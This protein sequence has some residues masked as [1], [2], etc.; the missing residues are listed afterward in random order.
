[1]NVVHEWFNMALLG[2]DYGER[3][4]GLAL[5]E[6]TLAVPLRVVRYAN[7]RELREE[8]QRACAEHDVRTIVAGV[9]QPL[10]G[11]ASAQTEA[12]EEFIGWLRREFVIPVVTEDERLTSAF[13]KRLM[14]DWKG[15]ADDDAI[16]ASL[17]LQSYIERTVRPV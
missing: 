7:R 2:I 4:I 16:A 12:S 15:K 1:M 3:K 13:A 17:I 9:P 8:L 10:G 11:G 5:A 14:R 6:G